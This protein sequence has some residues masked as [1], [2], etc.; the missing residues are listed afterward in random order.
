MYLPDFHATVQCLTHIIYGKKRHTDP[1]HGLHLYTGFAHTGCRADC[2]DT[3]VFFI[4]L[5]L[6][7]ALCHGN[8]MTERNEHGIVLCAHDSRNSCHCQHITLFS[9]A[10][11]YRPVYGAIYLYRA[12]GFR[13]TVCVILCMHIHHVSFTCLI[14][15]CELSFILFLIIDI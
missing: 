8:S 10:R 15:M 2:R 14:K 13:H 1:C 6:N 3:A 9:C 12:T 7:I 11:R 5:K 4:Q